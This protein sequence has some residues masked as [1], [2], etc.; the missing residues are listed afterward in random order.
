MGADV[1]VEDRLKGELKAGGLCIGGDSTFAAGAAEV[2]DPEAKSLK[3]LSP[4]RSAGI[5]V[6]GFDATEGGDG[7]VTCCVKE[8]FRAFCCG[9]SVAAGLGAGGFVVVPEKKWPP[10]RGGGEDICG[11]EGAAFV[12]TAVEKFN[13]ANP[14]D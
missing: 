14:E 7:L 11:A 4:K 5:D 9:A 1:V 2:V 6:A 13:P 10:L 12:G 3:P 8:K